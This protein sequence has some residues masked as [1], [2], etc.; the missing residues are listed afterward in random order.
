MHLS[1]SLSSWKP[2]GRQ[3]GAIL[4]AAL[5]LAAPAAQ[6]R[7]S[8]SISRDWRF[9]KGDPAG[10]QEDLRYDVRPPIEDADDGKLADARPDA[11]VAVDDA[12]A[13]VLKP[14]IL[15]SANPFIK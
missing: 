11:A 15:P 14:W 10:L 12:G 2:A 5:A 3:G 9:T 1:A 8:V 6:A 4:L 13:R 7:E